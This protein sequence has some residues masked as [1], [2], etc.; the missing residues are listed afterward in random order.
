MPSD[1]YFQPDMSS[2]YSCAFIK[3]NSKV[4]QTRLAC[5]LKCYVFK[6]RKDGKSDV[7]SG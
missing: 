3:N 6:M 5:Y 1:A 2:P 4:G 7:R